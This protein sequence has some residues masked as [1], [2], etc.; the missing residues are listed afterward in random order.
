MPSSFHSISSHNV[1]IVNKENNK[2]ESNKV[3]KDVFKAWGL[4]GDPYNRQRQVLIRVKKEIVSTL[5]LIYKFEQDG[6]ER[7]KRDDD[8]DDDS[9]HNLLGR[10]LLG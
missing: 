3:L 10:G 7:M 9:L 4:L 5:E 1:D 2:M 6:V 8:D